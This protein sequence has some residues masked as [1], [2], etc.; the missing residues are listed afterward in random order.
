MVSSCVAVLVT[1]IV[2]IILCLQNII[3]RSIADVPWF[4]TYNKIH[5][6]LNM[7]TIKEEILKSTETYEKTLS[8]SSKWS[9]LPA[10]ESHEKQMTKRCVI[11]ELDAT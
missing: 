11:L 4:T 9:S 7:F 1:R 5:E 2:T 3:L 6:N 10:V 8:Q